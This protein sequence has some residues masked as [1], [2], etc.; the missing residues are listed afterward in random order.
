MVE[1]VA[2][3]GRWAI[4]LLLTLG[5]SALAACHPTQIQAARNIPAAEASAY[6]DLLAYL[7][8]GR[9]LNFRCAGQGAPTVILESGYG[10]DSLAWPRVQS[11]L[12]KRY[13]VC[14]YDRAGYGFSD[15]GPEP[16]DGA[17]IARDLDRGLR[18]A[19]INGPLILV[20]HSAGALYVRLLAAR[21]PAEIRGLVLA[22]PTVEHQDRRFA[23]L[24]GP[25]SGS[26]APLRARAARCEA[27]AEANK[28][29][30]TNPDLARCVPA[31]QDNLPASV[32]AARR[33]EALRPSYW[34]ARASELENLFD[35]T[36]DQIDRS[37]PA[38][39]RVPMIVLT[40]G[41]AYAS[42][43]EPARTA[44]RSFWVQLHQEIA[45][46]T[47]RGEARIVQGSGHMMMKDR[48][49]AIIAA[50]D[51]MAATRRSRGASANAL[52]T[53]AG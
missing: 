12:S 23:E 48:P 45:A 36:S 30:S 28:L 8:D 50:V 40:A 31:A 33:A 25:G 46:R 27:A 1:V 6:P 24:L 15:P 34:R 16:R 49:D 35:R 52:A 11:E 44:V 14:A 7:P 29:P 13:R 22:D 26:L 9:R 51:E 3:R 20:G 4:H 39:E 5:L 47:L 17:A 53:P 41:D 32:N 2:P 43:P 19:R 42:L 10:A 21:R 37:A 18:A 38:L